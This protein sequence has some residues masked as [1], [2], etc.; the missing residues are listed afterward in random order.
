MFQRTTPFHEDTPWQWRKWDGL[1]HRL[2]EPNTV[3]TAL[4]QTDRR[5]VFIAEAK[6]QLG[7][8]HATQRALKTATV[9]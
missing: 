7:A 5:S 9:R 2:G 6:H 3:R 4:S 8:L 1:P